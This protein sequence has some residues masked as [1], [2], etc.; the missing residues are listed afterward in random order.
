M[1]RRSVIRSILGLAIAPKIL[2][3]ID[4]KPVVASP[5]SAS[6]FKDLYFAVPDYLPRLMEKYGNSSFMETMKM[7]EHI[8]PNEP[9][10]KFECHDTPKDPKE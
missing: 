6:L 4:F 10:I 1:N 3:E 7:Y 9:M 5:A 8:A 2:A